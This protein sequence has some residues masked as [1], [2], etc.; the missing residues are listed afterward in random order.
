MKTI[1]LVTDIAFW[2]N[3]FG[4]HMRIQ[5]LVR[6]LAQHHN[7]TVFFL[8]T[9]P[10]EA[11]GA[12]A[13]AGLSNVRLVGY[14]DYSGRRQPFTK[15]LCHMA[16]FAERAVE[17]F[18]SSLMAFL[19]E[20]P[21][22]MIILEYIR[23]AYLLD[24]CPESMPTV[25]DM[26]DVMSARTVSLRRAGLKPSIEL[27]LAEERVLLSRFDRVLAISRADVEHVVES[28]GLSNVIYAPYSVPKARRHVR[29]GNGRRLIFVGANSAPNVEGL[30]WFLAQVW[31]LLQSDDFILE[32][33]GTVCDAFGDALEGV[34]WRGQQ[35]DLSHC[36]DEA[37][38]AINPVF[39]GG[40]L[41]I[42]CIDALA[43]GLPCITTAEGAAGL[44]A[45]R[46]CGL[47]VASTRLD[48]AA[49]IRYLSRS[50]V[51]RRLVAKLAPQFVENEFTDG[52][53]YRHLARYLDNCFTRPALISA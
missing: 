46:G 18:V 1:V 43:A 10:A 23:L 20:K 40:G 42:K 38:I 17:D 22:D 47:F 34:V 28:I 3:S 11:R 21:A 19:A 25:L 32:V 6:Y 50:P 26:H 8:R 13:Y 9:L 30:R 2:E 5:S 14:K 52:S 12:M 16:C 15:D 39:V 51:D 27:P 45:A 49:A 35:N 48:F 31:P 41:K 29:R 4:S 44:E 24:G 36:L 37:D 33:V 53:A 7:V